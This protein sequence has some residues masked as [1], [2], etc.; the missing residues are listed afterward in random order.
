MNVNRLAIDFGLKK[1][2]L[3]IISLLLLSACVTQKAPSYAYNG[4][5]VATM[6]RRNELYN[7]M[8]TLGGAVPDKKI[9]YSTYLTLLANIPDT[10][11]VKMG[12]IAK[13]MGGYVQTSGTSMCTI[14]VPEEK[15]KEAEK[16]IETLGKVESKSTTGEDVTNEYADHAIRLENAQKAR[17]RYLDLLA[18]AENVEAALK[19]EKEL[20][21]L[22]ET[23]ELLKGQMQRI[24]HLAQ[25]ATITVYIKEKKKPGI[26]GYI[27]VGIFKAVKWLFVRN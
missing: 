6:G 9:I 3:S 22:N 12:E 20:E 13:R 21:R 11:V 4:S 27:G 2:C 14:R 19:V 16:E 7:D 18:K 1:F 5:D 25:Y 8:E 26:I 15:R 24:D 10:A 17:Q 23:I